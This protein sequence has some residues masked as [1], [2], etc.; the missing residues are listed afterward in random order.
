LIAGSGAL[1]VQV[2]EAQADS[3]FVVALEGEA[4]AVLQRYPHI[5][6]PIGQMKA[7]ADALLAAGCSNMVIIGGIERPNIE[8]L[9]FD[10]GGQWF[11]EQVMSGAHEGDDQLLKVIIAYFE[12]RGLNV[13]PAQ[14][15]LG[16]HTGKPGPQTAHDHSAHQSDIDRGIE[17]AHV[18]GG[19]DIGQSVAVG[20][21]LVLAIEGPE[22]TDGMLQRLRDLSPE[23]L[24]TAQQPSGVLVKLPKPQQDRRVDIPAIGRRTVELAAAAHLAGIVFEAGGTLF[25][26]FEAVV[27]LAE[28]KGL[29]LLGLERQS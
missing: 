21:R 15:Y 20:R 29:F 11:L 8:K 3:V 7:A 17:V 28:E 4:D 26:D 25:D 18:T 22:G 12:M 5:V 6:S 19:Q 23:F 27:E 1:P 14:N 9:E 2:A 24:G 13:C 16:S 10:E